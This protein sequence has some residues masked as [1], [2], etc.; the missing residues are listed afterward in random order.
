MSCDCMEKANAALAPHN[1]RIE[2][3]FTLSGNRV[4]MPWPISTVQIEKGRGKPKA[5][6]LVASFCPLCGASLKADAAP[7]HAAGEAPHG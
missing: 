3:I 5:M 6:G 1:T 7:P 4:G 2:Q